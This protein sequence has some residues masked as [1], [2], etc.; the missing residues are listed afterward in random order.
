MVDVPLDQ[1]GR[2]LAEAYSSDDRINH[3]QNIAVYETWITEVLNLVDTQHHLF[4]ALDLACG[5]GFTS[6]MLA[7]HLGARVTAVDISNAMLALGR[8]EEARYARSINYIQADASEPL[9]LIG[10]YDLVTPTFLLN[11]AQDKVM[12]RSFVANIAKYLRRGGWVVGITTNPTN[13]IVPRFPNAS[14]STEWIGE[15]FKNGSPLRLFQYDRNGGNLLDFVTYFWKAE[16]YFQAFAEVGLVD[17]KW[18]DLRMTEEGKKLFPNW[19]DLQAHNCA[20]VFTA[21]KR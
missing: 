17:L 14:H 4:R 3:Q 13:P 10:E 8:A 2:K 7:E 9:N 15:P 1:Y 5:G 6:R 12:F 18:V 16:M 19:K 21:R 20:V 11:Y